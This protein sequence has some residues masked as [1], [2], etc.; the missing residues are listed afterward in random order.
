MSKIL[1]GIRQSETAEGFHE[2]EKLL[3]MECEQKDAFFSVHPQSPRPLQEREKFKGLDYYPPT[4]DYRF[5]LRLHEHPKKERTKWGLRIFQ[6][7][8]CAR[9]WQR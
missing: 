2:W 6:R 9:H 4:I 8:K 1:S 3:K 5:E 7:E